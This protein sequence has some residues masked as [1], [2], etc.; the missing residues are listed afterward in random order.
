MKTV[1]V[2]KDRFCCDG[3]ATTKWKDVQLLI[4]QEW[5]NCRLS[6]DYS[7]DALVISMLDRQLHLIEELFGKFEVMIALK[8]RKRKNANTKKLTFKR[9]ALTDYWSYLDHKKG[10]W[11]EYGMRIL[12][13]TKQVEVVHVEVDKDYGVID[14]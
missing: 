14:E 3:F 2:V 13:L 4:D 5:N 8:I 10:R 7:D 6:E 12:G 11:C 9:V 1:F